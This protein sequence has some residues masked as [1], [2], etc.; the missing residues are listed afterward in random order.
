[1]DA[2]ASPVRPRARV[3]NVITRPRSEW[4]VIA[5]EPRDIAGLYRGYI[6]PLAAIPAVCRLIGMSLVGFAVPFVGFYRIDIGTAAVT[7]VVQY[8]LALVGVYVAAIVIAKLAPTFQSTPDAAQALKLVA[9]SMTPIWIAGILYLVPAL[10]PLVIL[11]ALWAIYVFYLGVAPVMKTP[12]DKVIP[13][14][15]ISAIAIVAVYIVIALVAAA[16]MP[17]A[18]LPSATM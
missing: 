6:A 3:V 1:M 11:A 7:A 18:L 4:P 14:M 15:V 5:A 17:L 2:Y 8:V 10:G 16:L 12:P 13:Y 9:Y